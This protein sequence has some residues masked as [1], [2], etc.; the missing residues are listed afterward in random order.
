MDEVLISNAS[1]RE[2]GLVDIPEG[3]VMRAQGYQ[4]VKFSILIRNNMRVPALKALSNYG[5]GAQHPS[6]APTRNRRGGSGL[7]A[8]R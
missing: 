3:P 2:I 4:P 6:I 8:N 5:N 1:A 7:T